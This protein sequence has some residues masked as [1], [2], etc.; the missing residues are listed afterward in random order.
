MD[1]F[2]YDSVESFH[3]FYHLKTNGVAEKVDIGLSKDGTITVGVCL[4]DKQLLRLN[5]SPQ[6][7]GYEASGVVCFLN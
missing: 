7:N 5:F 4:L 3:K 2:A 1:H 6:K